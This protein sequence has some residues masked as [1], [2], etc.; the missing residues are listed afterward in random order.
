MKLGHLKQTR[1]VVLTRI[2]IIHGGMSHLGGSFDERLGNRAWALLIGN[3]QW[4]AVT[5]PRTGATRIVFGANKVRQAVIPR[6]TIAA[7]IDPPVVVTLLTPHVK[8]GVD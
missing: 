8:H 2:E 4:S 5:V 3:M 7:H 1:P 6:P